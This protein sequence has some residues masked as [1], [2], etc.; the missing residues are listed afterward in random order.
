[1]NRRHLLQVLGLPVL[2][3]LA[4]PAPAPLTKPIPSS[5]E[6]LPVVGLGTWITFNVG[7]DPQGRQ[8]CMEVMRAF[9]A[10]GGRLIDSSPMYGS[11]QPVVGDGLQALGRPQALFA[12]DKVWTASD[13]AAQVEQSRQLWRVPRF[14]LLQVHNLLAW[15]EQLPLL[16][17]MKKEGRV[18]YVG[19]T[20]SEGRRHREFEQ[21]MR[22]HPLD[23]VQLT[24]NPVDR[25]AEQRLLPLA[26]ERG[27]AVL[28]N[29]P[30]QQGSLTRRLQRQPLPAFA[31]EIGCRSWAQLILKHIVSHPAITCAIPATSRVDHVRENL[32]AAAGPLPDEALRRRIEAH[33]GNL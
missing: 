6:P 33:I 28:A 27:I 25:E 32:A 19:I 24:Y 5:G 22:R 2:P 13:G 10:A 15:E 17:A 4:Q 30:F 3:A 21:V 26:R 14:D 29:R 18:R 20:T 1:M 11:S 8:Q 12:A 7:K 31:A 23:F 16:Q 9:F